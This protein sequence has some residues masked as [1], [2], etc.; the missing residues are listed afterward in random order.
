M[1]GQ[2]TASQAII[3]YFE[4]K[5]QEAMSEMRALSVEERKHLGVI[6]SADR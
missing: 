2:L 5:L 1:K 3:W 6:L 4:K